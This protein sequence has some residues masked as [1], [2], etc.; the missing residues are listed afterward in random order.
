M[1]DL[2]KTLW[3]ILAPL[4]PVLVKALLF[5]FGCKFSFWAFVVF[6]RTFYGKGR[7]LR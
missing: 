1:F 4:W 7:G 6:R 5:I 3:P 2:T